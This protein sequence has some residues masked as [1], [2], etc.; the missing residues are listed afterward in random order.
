MTESKADKAK[1]EALRKKV[2]ALEK[3]MAAI[4]KKHGKPKVKS[5]R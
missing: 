1:I 3:E 4:V 2:E 5:T